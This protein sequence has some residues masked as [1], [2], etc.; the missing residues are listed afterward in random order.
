MSRGSKNRSFDVIGKPSSTRG[1][2]QRTLLLKGAWISLPR[3]VPP[4]G[5]GNFV[6][7]NISVNSF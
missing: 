3:K 6:T 5:P 1:L 4:A 2:E 7:L